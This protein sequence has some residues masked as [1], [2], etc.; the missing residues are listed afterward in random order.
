MKMKRTAKRYDIILIASL[1]SVSLLSICALLIFR[2]DGRSVRVEVDGKVVAV[3]SL[4]DDGEY[5][6]NGG[7]NILV[8]ENGEAFI[9]TADCPDKT[10]VRSGRLKHTGES[11]VCLPNR[12]SVTVVGED[13]DGVDLVS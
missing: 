2:K 8:I 1:L 10:C 7:T 6:L 5:P 11:A 12:V 9:R 3:Y 13:T 4:S